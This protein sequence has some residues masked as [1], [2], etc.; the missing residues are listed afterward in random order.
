MQATK[1]ELKGGQ[2]VKM[3][4]KGKIYQG[5]IKGNPKEESKK[6]ATLTRGMFISIPIITETGSIKQMPYTS[7]ASYEILA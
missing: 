2:K 4:W 1:Y 3:E 5:I 6:S 7:K